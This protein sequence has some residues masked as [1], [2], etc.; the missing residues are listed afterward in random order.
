MEGL[1]ASAGGVA[2]RVC[3]AARAAIAG[4]KTFGAGGLYGR[5]GMPFSRANGADIWYEETG[6]GPNIVMVHANPFDHEM[7]MYQVAHFSNFF[8]VINIDLRGYGR[9]VKMVDDFT[10]EDMGWDVLGVMKDTGAD[11]AV[12]M[13]C[14]VGSTLGLL[15]GLDH[16]ERFNALILVGASS[17]RSLRFPRRIQG[18]LDDFPAYHR[19]FIEDLVHPNFTKTRMGRYLID[20]YLEKQ[21]WLKPE[22]VA[23]TLKATNSTVLT[24]RLH[25][26]EVRTLVINGE[27][28]NARPNG[29]LTSQLIPGAEHRVVMGA[30]HACCLEDPVAFDGFVIDFLKRSSLWPGGGAFT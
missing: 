9:S 13:G 11:K 5:T 3:A 23:A 29:E 25:T 1:D 27:M 2:G 4:T 15:L 7:W 10:L 12:F 20:N 14:S 30:G 19:V 17:D 22:A 18:Y 16:P 26:M 6:A 28:D 8:R 24:D 21:S